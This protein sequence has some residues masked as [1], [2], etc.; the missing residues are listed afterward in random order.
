MSRSRTMTTRRHGHD[1]EHS[2][3]TKSGA[4][5]RCPEGR[6]RLDDAMK[7]GVRRRS[8]RGG[9]NATCSALPVPMGVLL[10][11]LLRLLL[12]RP[13]SDTPCVEVCRC[14]RIRGLWLNWPDSSK[15][16]AVQHSVSSASLLSSPGP[17]GLRTSGGHSPARSMVAPA[18]DYSN[19]FSGRNCPF[20][21][22]P[23]GSQAAVSERRARL[24]LTPLIH[25]TGTCSRASNSAH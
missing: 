3:M 4:Q 9:G 16:S 23:T 1:E 2:P 15:S 13:E 21:E 17:L 7:T 18:R 22:T 25:S 11:G 8:N 5:R 24:R 19:N 10:S 12:S 6:R 14:F 20:P